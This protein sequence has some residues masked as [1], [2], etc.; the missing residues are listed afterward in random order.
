MRQHLVGT[1]EQCL[2]ESYSSLRKKWKLRRVHR[3]G[4]IELDNIRGG[5]S[6][7][8]FADRIDGR[9]CIYE[10]EMKLFKF[11]VHI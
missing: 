3:H 4:S 1:G 2:D 10:H 11:H 9:K 7:L 8:A 5:L 6:A